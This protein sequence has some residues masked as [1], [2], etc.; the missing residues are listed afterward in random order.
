M[1]DEKGDEDDD[2]DDDDDDDVC[3]RLELPRH[4]KQGRAAATRS[5]VKSRI[6]ET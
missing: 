2:D 3:T 4:D 1:L 6:A 5:F